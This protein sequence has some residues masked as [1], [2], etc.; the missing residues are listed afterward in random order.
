MPFEAIFEPD[1]A[2]RE[3]RLLE[4]CETTQTLKEEIPNPNPKAK[5]LIVLSGE[6]A[7]LQPRRSIR[8]GLRHLPEPDNLSFL[9]AERGYLGLLGNTY[10]ATFL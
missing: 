1:E 9:Q 7:S 8:A 5:T 6:K 3:K 4:A 10:R 2:P